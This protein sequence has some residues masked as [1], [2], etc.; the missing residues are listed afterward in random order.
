MKSK[1][2]ELVIGDIKE[3]MEKMPQNPELNKLMEDLFEAS[4]GFLIRNSNLRQAM[5][6]I[7]SV[8]GEVRTILVR[9]MK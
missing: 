2:L 4:R 8:N 7:R 9:A 1:E 3:H 6:D 5:L